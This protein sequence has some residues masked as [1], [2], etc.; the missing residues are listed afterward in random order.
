[1][2][3]RQLALLIRFHN[4]MLPAY[5][6][7][8]LVPRKR[9]VPLVAAN[10]RR[11]RCMRIP[12]GDQAFREA[13][14][15]GHGGLPR[16]VK[17]DDR[18]LHADGPVQAQLELSGFEMLHEIWQV[19]RRS[20]W[21]PRNGRASVSR[22]RGKRAPLMRYEVALLCGDSAG[23]RREQTQC[24]DARERGRHPSCAPWRQCQTR[25]H[26]LAT[27][28]SGPRVI[29]SAIV[30]DRPRKSE[31]RFRARSW[32]VFAPASALAACA[33]CSAPGPPNVTRAAA[34]SICAS[35]PWI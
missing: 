27:L 14:M 12:L 28:V 18:S 26:C 23:E 9:R 16:R 31:F 30:C 2:L 25:I 3:G 1:M 7:V 17:V 22:N 10:R 20:P 6:A 19:R 5:A 35:L 13:D 11:S 32:S 15:H 21:I 29:I 8:R 24:D 34:N 4:D 33:S